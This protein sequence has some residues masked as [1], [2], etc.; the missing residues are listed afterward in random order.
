MV[1]V[2]LLVL[3]GVLAYKFR[4]YHR[5]KA[6]HISRF[7]NPSCCSNNRNLNSFYAS[8][9]GGLK[10]TWNNYGDDVLKYSKDLDVD[11]R[12]AL[13]LIALEC[14]GRKEFKPRF[15][16]H[17]CRRLHAVKSGSLDSYENLTGNH[18]TDASDAAIQNLAT[19]WGPFQVMGYKCTQLGINVKDLRGDS[20]VYYGLKWMKAN[21][22]SLLKKFRYS[23]AFHVHNTGRVV[24]KSGNYQ[25]YDP[26]YIPKGLS[27]IRYFNAKLNQE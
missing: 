3:A 1:F 12:F 19:S 7:Y 8:D 17:V 15:E 10:A 25:T 22:G 18:L 26:N 4:V 14:S 27:Y 2:C 21:Y 11:P 9:E 20:A 16:Q 5:A 13:A 6:F 24:P 23:D